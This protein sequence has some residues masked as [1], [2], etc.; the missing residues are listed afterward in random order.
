[1]H[2]IV[3]QACSM[4]P[5]PFIT[6]SDPFPHAS[7]EAPPLPP[8]LRRK[9]SLTP[10]PNIEFIPYTLH[11]NLPRPELSC[12]RPHY[13]GLLNFYGARLAHRSYSSPFLSATVIQ[14]KS[15]FTLRVIESTKDGQFTRITQVG[16][17]SHGETVCS[18]L[19]T[20]TVIIK[21]SRPPTE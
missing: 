12:H 6:T 9:L 20:P 15:A 19:R 10:F 5:Y 11:Y 8:S 7:Q 17:V 16:P 18:C 14:T 21:H 1:V 3:R 4:K 2:N 13:V